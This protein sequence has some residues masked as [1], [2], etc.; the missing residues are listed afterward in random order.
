MSVRSGSDPPCLR[1]WLRTTGVVGLVEDGTIQRF[2]AETGKKA[3]GTTN[4]ESWHRTATADYSLSGDGKLLAAVTKPDVQLWSI[5]AEAAAAVS[6]RL[7]YGVNQSDWVHFHARQPVL[8]VGT[9][10]GL[11]GWDLSDPNRPRKAGEF[12]G[13]ASS[14]EVSE[15]NRR[16]LVT[17]HGGEVLLYEEERLQQVAPPSAGEGE[18]R[19]RFRNGQPERVTIG[20][21]AIWIRS[22]ASTTSS[23]NVD[24]RVR[25]TASLDKRTPTVDGMPAITGIASGPEALLFYKADAILIKPP[26]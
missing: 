8:F 21:E 9:A 14:L 4:L 22:L 17:T 15:D 10:S 2:D 5:P 3:A 18:P 24:R 26:S 6:H 16:F 20:E 7:E 19:I 13:S 12:D 11:V 1:L 23:R 25:T